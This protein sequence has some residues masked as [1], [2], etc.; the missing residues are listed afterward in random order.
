MF[1][2]YYGQKE[3]EQKLKELKTQLADMTYVKLGEDSAKT[4]EDASKTQAYVPNLIF[5][6]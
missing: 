4:M 2:G 1:G 5:V 6:G 3:D